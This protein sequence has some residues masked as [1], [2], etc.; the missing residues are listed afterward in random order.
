MPN[1]VMKSE[2]LL[3][4]KTKY[5]KLHTEPLQTKERHMKTTHAVLHPRRLG[6][7]T[8]IFEVLIKGTT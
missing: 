4:A 8:N 7:K 1:E 6:T 3:N 2:K 5:M